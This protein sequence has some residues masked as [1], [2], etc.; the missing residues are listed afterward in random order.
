VI[1]R[2]I[3]GI[4]VLIRLSTNGRIVIPKEMRERLGLR[5]GAE[6]SISL[7]GNRIVLERQNHRALLDSLY[8]R[9]DGVDFLT[10]LE[11][12]HREELE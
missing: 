4:A 9:F 2:V 6:L 10:E 11:A 12:E 5:P 7:E 1:R 3:G 8:G